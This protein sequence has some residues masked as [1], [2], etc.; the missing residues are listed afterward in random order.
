MGHIAFGPALRKSLPLLLTFAYTFI[1]SYH[2]AKHQP[3]QASSPLYTKTETF[4]P[5]LYLH[6]FQMIL[7]GLYCDY[8]L[9]CCHVLI[10]KKRRR[11]IKEFLLI[12]DSSNNYSVT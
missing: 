10:V 5:R 6:M 8:L 4:C 3:N 9:F 12:A 2:I 11:K 1:V 7:R